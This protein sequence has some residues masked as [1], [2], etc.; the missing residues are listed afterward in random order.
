M[1]QDR[2]HIGSVLRRTAWPGRSALIAKCCPCVIAA[3]HLSI[4][5]RRTCACAVLFDSLMLSWLLDPQ[6]CCVKANTEEEVCVTEPEGNSGSSNTV[7][8]LKASSKEAFLSPNRSESM[9]PTRLSSGS[10]K[11]DQDW[12]LRRKAAENLGKVGP[13]AIDG[14]TPRLMEALRD[15]HWQVRRAAANSLRELGQQAVEQAKD[16]LCEACHDRDNLVSAAAAKALA[17]HG[18]T[19]PPPRTLSD[20]AEQG[21]LPNVAESAGIKEDSSYC[22]AQETTDEE[23]SADHAKKEMTDGERST[24][25]S[26]KTQ[27]QCEFAM[28]LGSETGHRGRLGIDIDFGHPRFLK[29]LKVYSGLIQDWNLAHPDMQVEVGDYFV[30]INGWSNNARKLM[31]VLTLANKLQIV[32]RKGDSIS[33]MRHAEV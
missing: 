15:E 28:T 3:Q 1:H 30:E 20:Q 32:V 16:A 26:V 9:S 7:N 14:V 21:L 25:C 33:A 31:E 23:A 5:V 13:F 19:V 6:F 27:Q 11:V 8:A 18:L 4:R 12:Q 17:S 22:V 24:T 29:I 2:A 10:L